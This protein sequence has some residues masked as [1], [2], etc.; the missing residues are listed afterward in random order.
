MSVER[1]AKGVCARNPC[2]YV[3]AF[4]R[5][6]FFPK[7]TKSFEFIKECFSLG[8]V[9]GYSLLLALIFGPSFEP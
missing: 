9:C 5:F 2:K 8:N 1:G 3:I 4:R 7:F 6:R